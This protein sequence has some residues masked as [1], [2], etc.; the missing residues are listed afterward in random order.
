[1]NTIQEIFRRY[2]PEY[3]DLHGEHL[4]QNHRKAIQAI[5]DCRSGC[6]G[7]SFYKCEACG[8]LHAAHRSCGN[9]HCPTCQHEKATHWLNQRLEQLLPCHYFLVTFTVPE[10]LR[11]CMR[12]HPRI[13]YDA[14]FAAASKTLKKLASDRRFVGAAHIGF[15]GV[16]HTWG[17]QLQYHP[18]LHFVVPGGGLSKDR[19]R[20]MASKTH[21]LVHVKA[22]SR[23]FRRLLKKA[24]RIAGLLQQLS[25]TVWSTEFNVNCQAVGSGASSLKYLAPYVFRVAISNSRILRSENHQVTFRYRKPKSRQLRTTTLDA[26]EFIRRFLQHVLPTG[27]MKIRHYGFLSKSCSVSIPTIRQMISQISEIAPSEQNLNPPPVQHRLLTCRHCGS[28][29][30]FILFVPPVARSPG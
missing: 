5:I 19:S 29:L 14:M 27:F 13:A 23:M 17:R 28:S 26:L 1:M 2:A 20:W 3:L 18:H 12:A 9:R 22:A 25:P 21:F 4:P 11:A 30:T 16:L 7:T 8:K 24:F 6:L 15:F 10:P